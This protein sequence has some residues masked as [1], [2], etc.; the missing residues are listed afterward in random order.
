MI[1]DCTAII[2][3]GGN[4]QR[5]GSDKAR[6]IID[7]QPLLHSVAATMG[8]LFASVVL[9]VRQPRNDIDLPQYCDDRAYAGPLAGLLGGMERIATPWAFVIACDMPFVAV[10]MVE[11]LALR[12]GRC[13]AVVPVAHGYPQPLAAFYARSALDDIGVHLSSG[14]KPSM[15]AVLEKLQVRYVHDAELRSADPLLHSFIDLDTPEDFLREV[16]NRGYGA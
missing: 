10:E 1:D 16:N 15:R 13:Q 8:K 7:G 9:S 14:G 5:M 12:R 2:L 4:S 3:A 6:L 11:L